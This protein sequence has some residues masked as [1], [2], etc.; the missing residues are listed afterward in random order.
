MR[1]EKLEKLLSR[2][3]ALKDAIRGEIRAGKAR[4]QKALFGAV[5]RAGLL[6]LSDDEIEAALKAYQATRGTGGNG[7]ETP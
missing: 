2:Q 3:Q 4:K 7:G 6:D 5:Q 1:N